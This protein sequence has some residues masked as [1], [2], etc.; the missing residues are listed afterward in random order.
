MAIALRLWAEFDSV[1]ETARW[2]RRA[3][4][5]LLAVFRAPQPSSQSKLQ[6]Q[7][8]TQSRLLRQ[9]E[10]RDSYRPKNEQHEATPSRHAGR[11]WPALQ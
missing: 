5:P 3:D 8:L 9:A 1:R 10:S 2:K 7:R 4:W 11:A 6:A